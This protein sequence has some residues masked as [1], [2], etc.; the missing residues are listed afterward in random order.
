MSPAE[1]NPHSDTPYF[2]KMSGAD[3]DNKYGA[4]AEF[5]QVWRNSLAA[6]RD[7]SVEGIV[8]D[9]EFYNYYKEYDIAELAHQTGKTPAEAAQG[10]KQI[11]AKMADIAAETY[12]NAKIWLLFTGLTHP[13]YKKLDGIPY[14]PSPTYVSIGLLDEIVKI[15]LPLKVIAG[16]EGS[17]GYCH[18]SLEE[19]RSSI[20]KRQEALAAD[21]QKY[22]GVLELGGTLALWS[23]RAAKK[24][25]LNRGACQSSDASTI[26][27]LQPYIE[28]LLHTYSYNWL[29]GTSEGNYLPFSPSNAPRFDAVISKAKSH[30]AGEVLNPE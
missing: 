7:S 8:C 23:D 5:L 24:D 14:Y 15:K 11:G 9:L 4:L 6:A 10:L 16:G 13:G 28:L 21:L 3:L 27:E 18:D 22:N 20:Q 25:W 17:I 26:E 30:I 19:F 1:N 2:R 29:Y 12:P